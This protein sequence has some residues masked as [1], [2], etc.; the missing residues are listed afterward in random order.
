[1][2]S[3]LTAMTVGALSFFFPLETLFLPPH[4]SSSASEGHK[5]YCLCAPGELL[6]ADFPSLAVSSF[7]LPPITT[8]GPTYWLL[9]LVN[10]KVHLPKATASEATI[11]T[12]SIG[13]SRKPSEALKRSTQ[14][15]RSF[16]LA[17]LTHWHHKEKATKRI[18]Q[19]GSR[20]HYRSP[21]CKEKQ[22]R[23]PSTCAPQNMPG[24]PPCS[25]RRRTGRPMSLCPNSPRSKSC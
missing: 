13:P 4:H 19:I 22:R 17:Q 25:S 2:S 16:S 9:P 12:Y 11:K 6:S 8:R 23:H 21:W 10:R 15:G 18:E 3:F 14:S 1:M 5:N 7:V 24:F 20:K